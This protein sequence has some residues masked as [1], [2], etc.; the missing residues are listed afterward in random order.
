MPPDSEAAG[1][2]PAWQPSLTPPGSAGHW[3]GMQDGPRATAAAHPEGNATCCLFPLE[4][5]TQVEGSS[6]F[7]CVTLITLNQSYDFVLRVG[8]CPKGVLQIPKD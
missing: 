4:L 6:K 8:L 7:S 2:P 3:P 1:C 5:L